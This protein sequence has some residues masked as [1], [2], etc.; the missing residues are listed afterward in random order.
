M[1]VDTVRRGERMAMTTK[2]TK[3]KVSELVASKDGMIKVTDGWG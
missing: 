1:R 3:I 2:F